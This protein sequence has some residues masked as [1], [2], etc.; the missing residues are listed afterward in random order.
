MLGCIKNGVGDGRKRKKIMTAYD[1]NNTKDEQNC[2][3]KEK[4]RKRVEK[5]EKRNTAKEKE[6]ETELE[7]EGCSK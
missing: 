6:E 3:E 7:K 2:G 1:E 4:A 5:K